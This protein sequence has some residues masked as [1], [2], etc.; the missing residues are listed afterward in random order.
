[1]LTVA[2]APRDTPLISK[3]ASS[4]APCVSLIMPE[5]TAVA[6]VRS[7]GGGDGMRIRATVTII[8][9]RRASVCV[10]SACKRLNLHGAGLFEQANE[11][12]SLAAIIIIPSWA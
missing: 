7:D 2:M 4:V 1:M 6:S 5:R 9:T 11:R 10:L 8:E 12:R 3:Y